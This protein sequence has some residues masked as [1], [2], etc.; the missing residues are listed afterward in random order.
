MQ[1]PSKFHQNSSQTSKN[2]TQLHMEKQKKNRIAETI[3][4]NKGTPKDNTIP[5]FKLYYRAKV[6]KTGIGIKRNWR[7]NGIELKTQISIHT[8]INTSFLTKKKKME[9]RNHI[10][11]MVLA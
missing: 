10:Q 4:Y 5:D 2:N 8:P 3:L 1:C 9:N 6:L 11:Q 7:T